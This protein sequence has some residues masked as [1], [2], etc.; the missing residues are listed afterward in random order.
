[1]DLFCTRVVFQIT[2]KS[3]V[4][5]LS[6]STSYIDKSSDGCRKVAAT[7]SSCYISHTS[8]SGCHTCYPRCRT[9]Y[10]DSSWSGSDS[11]S[12][13][14]STYQNRW[15]VSREWT[16][17]STRTNGSRW[18]RSRASSSSASFRVFSVVAIR[19]LHRRQPN[20]NKWDGKQR[21]NNANMK[22]TSNDRVHVAS[23]KSIDWVKLI[24]KRTS[25]QNQIF[26][27]QVAMRSVKRKSDDGKRKSIAS[28]NS[29]D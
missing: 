21:L 14:R 7:S 29:H 11:C 25:L 8:S 6:T 5:R 24:F 3:D 9:R 26:S 20:E 16:H 17:Q 19:C 23:T 22:L 28:R 4:S 1:M 2:S 10:D 27:C 15:S 13:T 12:T 18:V